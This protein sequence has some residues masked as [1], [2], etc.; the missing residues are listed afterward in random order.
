MT[1]STSARPAAGSPE[2]ALNDVRTGL[3]ARVEERISA[4]MVSE[5]E[6][7]ATV[8]PRA[9]MPIDAVAALLA[10]GG[11]R[12][13]PAFCI[14]GYL[15]AGG[16]PEDPAIV[17]AA[18]ALELLQAFALI[19]DDVLDD[20]PMRRGMLTAHV[21]FAAEHVERGWRGEPRRFGEGVA[22]LAGDLAHV[23]ADRL[24]APLQQAA[25]DVWDELRIEMV[26]GQTLDIAVAA[27]FVTD[28]ALARWIA[29]QKSGR[30][31]I[32]RP[33]LLGAAL[34][35]RADLAPQFEEYG[36][37]LGEAFQLRDD[38]IDA[39]GEAAAAGKPTG[40][41]FA[42]QKMTLLLTLAV[43]RHERVRALVSGA[44]RDGW[45]GAALREELI[46]AGGRT[47]VERHIDQLVQQ[48]CTAIS[49]APLAPGWP[50]DLAGL[51]QLVAYRDR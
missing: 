43:Q 6:R 48:A 26:I 34:A 8:D 24:M 9:T 14:S 2:R 42:G 18:T 3:L 22:I 5:R 45:D 28:T 30:Y 46:L 31:T 50:E 12:I 39:F 19:H 20:S 15:A 23:W 49:R 41:D 13:R 33:L 32:H 25:R 40:L 29:V 1:T 37:A 4:L 16:D 11:K 47:E 7:W 27:E 44:G 35:G 21:R 51:A 36:Q 17:D 38:L 10:A